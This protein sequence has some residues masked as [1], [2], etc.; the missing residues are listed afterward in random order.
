MQWYLEYDLRSLGKNS[1]QYSKIF[2]EQT[3]IPIPSNIVINQFI[4]KSNI[5]LKSN[6]ELQAKSERF[7]KRLK[8]NF[9]IGKIT[10]NLQNFYEYEFSVLLAELKKQKITLPL[11]QQDEWEDYFDT[12]KQE[13]NQVQNQIKQTDKEIDQ[14]VYQLYELTEEEIGIVEGS[15]K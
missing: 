4:E 6:K 2:I 5:I 11:K 1:I 3:P 15:V 12:Y 7:I 9:N 13:I 8:I 14:M 10:E